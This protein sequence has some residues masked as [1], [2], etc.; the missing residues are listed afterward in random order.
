MFYLSRGCCDCDC[1]C[2]CFQSCHFLPC[3]PSD[4]FQ[5]W[6]EKEFQ[7]GKKNSPKPPLHFRHVEKI[8]EIDTE[9]R[10]K[11]KTN[12]YEFIVLKMLNPLNAVDAKTPVA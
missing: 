5:R 11:R 2:D 12:S 3:F 7:R 9:K 6:V 4:R 1:D 8:E 10:R